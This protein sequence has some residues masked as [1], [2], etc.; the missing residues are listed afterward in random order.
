[1]HA[2][3]VGKINPDLAYSSELATFLNLFFYFQ[4][5]ERPCLAPTFQQF[6]SKIYEIAANVLCYF[7][8]LCRVR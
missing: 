5:K 4:N 6:C 7:Y 1:V 2:I 3:N 8:G